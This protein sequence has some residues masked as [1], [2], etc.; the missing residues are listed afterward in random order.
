MTNQMFQQI[1]N[2]AYAHSPELK[3]AFGD[4]TDEEQQAFDQEYDEWLMEV[5]E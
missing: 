3:Q 5:G 4:W 2:A 1:A